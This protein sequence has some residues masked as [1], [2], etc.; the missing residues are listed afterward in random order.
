LFLY[1]EDVALHT[2]DTVGK[3]EDTNDG[4]GAVEGQTGAAVT[5][6]QH[7]LKTQSSP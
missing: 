3:E 7:L 2:G 4:G 6:G 1:L 5:I